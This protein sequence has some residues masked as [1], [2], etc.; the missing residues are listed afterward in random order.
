MRAADANAG[1]A[2]A[3]SVIVRTKDR[4]AL[5]AEALASVAAQSSRDLELV[6]VNDGGESVREVVDALQP[7]LRRTLVGPRQ[8]RPFD[9]VANHR[10][11]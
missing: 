7:P 9:D 3:V 6:V 11:L 4:P 10:L 2:P 8:P 1:P 5:L